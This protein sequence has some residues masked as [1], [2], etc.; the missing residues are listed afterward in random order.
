MMIQDAKVLLS[1]SSIDKI[2]DSQEAGQEDL[3]T[4]HVTPDRTGL[5]TL[6]SPIVPK[7]ISIEKT[8]YFAPWQSCT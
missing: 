3:V 8:S 7:V 4:P 2:D 5:K 6:S 1:L